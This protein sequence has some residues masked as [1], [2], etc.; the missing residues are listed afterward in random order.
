VKRI[1][2]CLPLGFH[3]EPQGFLPNP[4]LCHD[5]LQIRSAK[6]NHGQQAAASARKHLRTSLETFL[7]LFKTL[8]D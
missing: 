4:P 6:G 7:E 2:A 1:E 5:P 8:L 3:A